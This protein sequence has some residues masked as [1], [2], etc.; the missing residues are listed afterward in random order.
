M[1][2][3]TRRRLTLY[4][5]QWRWNITLGWSKHGRTTSG[6]ACHHPPLTAYTRS[7]DVKSGMPS[8]PL[9]NIHVQKTSGVACYHCPCVA[10]GWAKSGFRFHHYPQVAHTFGLCRAWIAIINRGCRIHTNLIFLLNFPIALYYSFIFNLIWHEAY[11]F[12]SFI[13]I[14]FYTN[15]NIIIF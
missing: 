4:A 10:L 7:D 14:L 11:Y 1:A 5:A 15:K 9:D 3:H 12:S 2:C 8:S 13:F 6:E